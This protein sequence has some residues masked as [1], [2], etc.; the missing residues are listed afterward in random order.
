M[1]IVDEL[2]GNALEYFEKMNCFGLAHG[3]NC[4]HT[5]GSGIAGQIVKKWPKVLESDKK[6]DCGNPSKLGTYTRYQPISGKSIFNVYT[7]YHFNPHL[8]PVNYEAIGKGFGLIDANFKDENRFLLIPKIGAG[9]AGGD[10]ATIRF[11]IN[12]V[13]PNLQIILVEL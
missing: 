11:I 10:W 12:S 6:T 7:Q 1:P 4:F 3:C 5:M 2:K 13:T 9:L 8:K